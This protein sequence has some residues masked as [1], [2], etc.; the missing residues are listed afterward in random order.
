MKTKLE[1]DA[2]ALKYFCILEKCY[3]DFDFSE[4]I[5]YLAEDS[6]LR[7]ADAKK[8]AV[9]RNEVEEY[10]Q[11]VAEE[12]VDADRYVNCFVWE[13]T[14]NPDQ[15]CDDERYYPTGDVWE[16]TRGKNAP[17]GELALCVESAPDEY[18]VIRLGL[19]GEYKISRME[20]C[21]DRFSRV[22]FY[23]MRLH[24][25]KYGSELSEG[26]IVINEK[27]LDELYVF[28][29]LAGSN[30]IS[31]I[32]LEKWCELLR[33]WEKF[34]SFDNFDDA[35]EYVCGIDY[36]SFTVARPAVFERMSKKGD[37]IWER[38]EKGSRVTSQLCLWTERYCGLCNAVCVEE[39]EEQ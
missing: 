36:G 14:E 15:P 20:I 22:R 19:D 11:G 31:E 37:R 17:Y 12:L 29:M 23:S 7:D 10:L 25:A 26:D 34:C 8:D 24:L 5:P 3:D 2:I 6:L 35:F 1:L 33:Y 16:L 18:R 38:R 21:E 9:G 28:A 30:G 39:Y 13:L 32:S 4:L 27:F